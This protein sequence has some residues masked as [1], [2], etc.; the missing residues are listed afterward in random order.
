MK[1]ILFTVAIASAII[2]NS[3][4]QCYECSYLTDITD[5]SGNVIDTTT[6]TE[7]ICTADTEIITNREADGEL[8]V[9][10]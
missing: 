10:K 3:C 5:G 2:L 9:V 7:D 6:V 1:P 8:C 4:S